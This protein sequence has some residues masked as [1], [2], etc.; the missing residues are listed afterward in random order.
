MLRL[1]ETGSSKLSHLP[2]QRIN[3]SKSSPVDDAQLAIAVVLSCQAIWLSYLRLRA[4]AQSP[5]KND[6]PQHLVLAVDR[7]RIVYAL[8]PEHCPRE[9]RVVLES[10]GIQGNIQPLPP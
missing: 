2:V 3:E 8:P 4:C 5:I 7:D 10:P 6:R 9:E 1:P